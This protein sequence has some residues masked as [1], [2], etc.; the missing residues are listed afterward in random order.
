MAYEIVHAGGAR[1]LRGTLADERGYRVKQGGQPV[2]VRQVGGRVVAVLGAEPVE[3]YKKPHATTYHREYMRQ[4]GLAL[5]RG[6][7]GTDAEQILDNMLE[8]DGI[9]E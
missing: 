2:K 9:L 1:V 3:L 5:Y 6:L 4:N 7:P 8:Y